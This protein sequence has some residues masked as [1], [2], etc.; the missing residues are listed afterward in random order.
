MLEL[1]RPHC[2]YSWLLALIAAF[3]GCSGFA[4]RD[5]APDEIAAETALLNKKTA[6]L[7][8]ENKVLRDENL[9]LTR[10]IELQR[11]ELQKKQAEFVAERDKL[12]AQ[13][14]SAEGSIANL[15]EKI[16]ILESESGGK[17]RQLVALNEQLSKKAAEDL[18]QAQEE[19]ARVQR[20]AA[21]EQERLSK[22]SAE[23]Q[24][25]LSREIQELKQRLADAE[26]N[27]EEL[28]R[29]LAALREVE[30][31]LRRQ[32]AER[33]APTAPASGKP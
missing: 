25:A 31:A 32:L 5:R 23:K 29:S 20:E 13:L 7:E 17:I 22:A 8:R 10:A 15:T 14:K 9:E 12:T 6:L 27:N 30:A 16:Q 24:F 33:G 19:L 3:C 4:R 21:Q 18:K 2:T 26:K 11:A 28:R 1:M